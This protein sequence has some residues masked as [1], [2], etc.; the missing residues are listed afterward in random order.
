MLIMKVVRGKLKM[1]ILIMIH[2]T[3]FYWMLLR[4]Q[5]MRL[6]KMAAFMCFMRI[7]KVLISVEHL[8]KLVFIYL[9]LVYGR[10]NHLYL[11]V[12]LISG[13]TN[14]YYLAGTRRVNIAG[15]QIES[16]RL[17]GSLINLNEM[18]TIQR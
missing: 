4:T 9:E 2:F 8:K 11:A 14:R 12:H 1:T 5:K 17:F 16:N 7:Q 3:S 10:N 15:I 13:N 18:P 6:R